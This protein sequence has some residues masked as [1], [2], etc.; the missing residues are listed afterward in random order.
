MLRAR[1]PID[2]NHFLVHCLFNVIVVI[3]WFPDPSWQS[4]CQG[5]LSPLM[6]VVLWLRHNEGLD[7]PKCPKVT[8]FI[9]HIIITSCWIESR[10][11]DSREDVQECHVCQTMRRMGMKRLTQQIH[12]GWISC[13]SIY[14]VNWRF[15]DD[16]SKSVFMGQWQDAIFF[17]DL[18]I[19]F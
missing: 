13:L 2:P 19:Y 15:I 12:F 8:V 3:W 9:A 16:G 14:R 5:W 11:P 18:S 10:D 17:M 4:H 6:G 1:Y 7:S